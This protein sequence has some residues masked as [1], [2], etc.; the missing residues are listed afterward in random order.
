VLW[1]QTTVITSQTSME[2]FQL[3]RKRISEQYLL[4]YF[5]IWHL[6]QNTCF[7]CAI[8]VVISHIINAAHHFN[9]LNVI[10]WTLYLKYLAGKARTNWDTLISERWESKAWWSSLETML[11]LLL[12]IAT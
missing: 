10:L 2:L 12:R 5:K 11:P 6:H 8:I 7:L 4:Q 3:P 1:N 9:T